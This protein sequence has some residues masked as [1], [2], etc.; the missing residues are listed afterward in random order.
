ME[1]VR[2]CNSG[3]EACLFSVLAAQHVTKRRKI[4]IFNGCYH[5]G[6]MIYGAVDPPLSVP[7]ELVKSTYNDIEGTRAALRAGADSI[8]T[9]IVEPVMG[10]GGCIPGTQAFLSMLR[11]ETQKHDVVLI[12]DEVGSSRLGPGGIQGLFGIVPDMTTLGKFW[13]G[14]F[15]FGAFGGSRQ[16][17]RHFDLRSDGM[18]SQGGTFNNNI[19]TMAAG[20]AGARDVYTPEACVKLN[21]LGDDLREAINA[22]GVSKGIALQATGSG[23]MMN[24]HWQRGSITHPGDVAPPGHPLRRLFQLEMMLR[25]FYVAQRGLITLSLPYTEKD[26]ADFLHAMSDYVAEYGGLIEAHQ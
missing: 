12:F 10:A 7:F 1:L 20:L 17:M 14:G 19:M 25:G 9:V 2:F 22:I 4:V 26:I 5:G 8:A 23:A 11:E 24:T 15:N 18:L 16:I 21:K 13:G 6:F 3:S